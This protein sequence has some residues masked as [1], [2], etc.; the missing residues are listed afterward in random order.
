LISLLSLQLTARD[1]RADAPE[2]ITST[3]S[4]SN[5]DTLQSQ[6]LMKQGAAKYARGDWLGAYEA[7]ERAWERTPHP[8]VAANM[9]ATEIKL[10][11]YLRAATH[12]KYALN[13]LPP[14]QM[15]KRGAVQE[16]LEQ[17]RE[18]L[19]AVSLAANLEGVDIWIDGTRVGRTPLAE[20][21]LLE[22]GHHSI[23][24]QYAGAEQI[25]ALDLAAGA[26]I[27]LVFD[28][29]SAERLRAQSQAPAPVSVSDLPSSGKQRTRTWVLIGGAAATAI[30]LGVGVAMRVESKH[31]QDDASTLSQQI[32][33]V[34]PDANLST[35]SGCMRPEQPQACDLLSRSAAAAHRDRNISTA[36]FLAAGGFG[37]ATIATFLLWPSSS[38]VM[39]P[40]HSGMP[41]LRL[42]TSLSA[43]G[44][45]L[46]AHGTF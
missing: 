31:E 38:G 27:D 33:S 21:V 4:A 17:L 37:V 15:E 39:K 43:R 24:A 11:K 19:V 44:F 29:S 16:Q 45:G 9:A 36:A 3:Q 22:P 23:R 1:A 18:H 2:E 41:R 46:S 6:E 32:N 14:V 26:R 34:S 40:E 8:A 13:H 20:E 30:S 10:G 5:D 35:N 7:Y 25:K 42:G 12:L 28:L